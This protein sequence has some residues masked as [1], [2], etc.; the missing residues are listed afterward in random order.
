[1]D[2]SSLSRKPSSSAFGDDS[3]STCRGCLS[4]FCTPNLSHSLLGMAKLKIQMRIH[5]L[6]VLQ[7]ACAKPTYLEELLRLNC[8]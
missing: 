3:S 6:T 8:E 1:M 5:G 7:C 2:T 4:F